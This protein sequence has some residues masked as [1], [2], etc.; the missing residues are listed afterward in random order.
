M[1][2]VRR[3][4]FITCAGFAGIML[5]SVITFVGPRVRKAL[6]TIAPQADA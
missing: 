5:P 4:A 6:A 3:T 1:G 2:G